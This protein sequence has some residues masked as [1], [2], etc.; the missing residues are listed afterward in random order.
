[1]TEAGW[2]AWGQYTPCTWP[3]TAAFHPTTTGFSH[4]Y[5]FLFVSKNTIL[6]WMLYFTPPP[7]EPQ[8]GSRNWS[9]QQHPFPFRQVLSWTLKTLEEISPFMSTCTRHSF[10][11]ATN[12]DFAY[13]CGNK[14]ESFCANQVFFGVHR[15][16][17]LSHICVQVCSKIF[18]CVCFADVFGGAPHECLTSMHNPPQF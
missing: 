17:F 4:F 12:V 1:M 6:C 5:S 7:P 13:P 8:N 11:V 14:D 16:R 3:Q 9:V 2:T 18:V 15:H 10:S